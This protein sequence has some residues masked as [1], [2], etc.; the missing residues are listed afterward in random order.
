MNSIV[1]KYR[2][3]PTAP[4]MG[5]SWL[6]E[7]NEAWQRL[8]RRWWTR[9][10][11]RWWTR[12]WKGEERKK[13]GFIWWDHLSK[14]LTH[15]LP[16]SWGRERLGKRSVGAG[17]VVTCIHLFLHCCKEIPDTGQGGSCLWSQHF[18]RLRWVDVQRSGVRD[19]PGQH[20]ETLSL[21]KI[22][23]LAKHGGVCL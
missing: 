7:R 22:Q 10:R 8:G 21:L 17:K 2:N 11:R 18:G 23:K 13:K 16:Y 5:L 9:E 4:H 15:Y 6:I 14:V 3:M 19:Q 20:G 12:E 1:K